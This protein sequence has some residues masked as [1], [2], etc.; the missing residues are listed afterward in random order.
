M[1]TRAFAL[2]TLAFYNEF[3]VFL[4]SKDIVFTNG[5]PISDTI[6]KK[7]ATMKSTAKIAFGAQEEE[8]QSE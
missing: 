3:G 5:F 8:V 7:Y 2:E 6:L 4:D 1:D